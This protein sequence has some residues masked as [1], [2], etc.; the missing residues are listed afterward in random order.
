MSLTPSVNSLV[1]SLAAG[2][3]AA[4]A[5]LYERVGA[6]L[7]TLTGR[8]ARVEATH[9]AA[10]T[11]VAMTRYRLD[12]GAF[13]ARLADLVPAYLDEVPADPFD[14]SPLR[15]T[16][17]DGEWLVYSIGPDGKDDGGVP[18][19]DKLHTGDFVF[20]LKAVGPATRPADTQP[21]SGRS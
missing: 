18:F 3:P 1:H 19:D 11:A 8:A 6:S 17:K 14:G 4:Y 12:H 15:M 10:Q 7:L 5:A 16:V 20:R 2:R 9:A 13:P 21:V